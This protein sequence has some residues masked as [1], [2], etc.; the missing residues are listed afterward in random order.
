ELPL[1]SGHGRHIY[2]QFVIR[3]RRRD[4]LQAYL[5]SQ[6]IGSAIYYPL[7]LHLQECFQDLGY[8]PGDFPVSEAAAKETLALPIYPELTEAMLERVVEAV[9]DFYKGCDK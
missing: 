7:P 2:N 5:K 3:A 9:T 8:Q 4:E 6:Q 1:D